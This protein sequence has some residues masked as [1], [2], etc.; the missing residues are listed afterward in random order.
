[1]TADTDAAAIAMHDSGIEAARRALRPKGAGRMAEKKVQP[2]EPAKDEKAAG[3]RKATK[4]SSKR[5]LHKRLSRRQAK[6]Y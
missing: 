5:M 4:T 1:M 2:K 3:A 6:K